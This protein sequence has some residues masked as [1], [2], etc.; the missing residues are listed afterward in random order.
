VAWQAEVAKMAKVVHGPREPW[1]GPIFLTV[2]FYLKNNAEELQ[3]TLVV[4][5]FKWHEATGK[6]QHGRSV[7]DMTN[8]VKAVEDACNG[9][10][11]LDDTQVRFSRAACYWRKNPGVAITI[12]SLV[13]LPR[14]GVTVDPPG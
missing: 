12:T 7:A 4:P 6:W 8:L 3:D 13:P 2:N 5:S 9:I 11:Y 10:I 1:L 14:S